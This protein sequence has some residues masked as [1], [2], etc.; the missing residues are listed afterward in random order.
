MDR[1]RDEARGIPM[2]ATAMREQ[3]RSTT[4]MRN[5]PAVEDREVKQEEMESVMAVMKDF[6]E[7][8]TS[9]ND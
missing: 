9:A 2:A 8:Q 7:Q 4:A 6:M 5:S 1:K 3:H